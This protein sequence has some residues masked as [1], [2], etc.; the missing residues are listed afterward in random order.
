[1]LTYIWRHPTYQREQYLIDADFSITILEHLCHM[2][3]ATWLFLG[4]Y[5]SSGK[6]L[7]STLVKSRSR[8]I[9]CY[10]G[11]IVVK[12]DRDFGSAAAEMLVKFQ[13]YWKML[14]PNLVASRL[15]EILR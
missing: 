11:R 15:R 6:E 7:P 1:M 4:L 9:G 13:S 3:V 12:F 8:E 5:S 10:N 14:N 2:M